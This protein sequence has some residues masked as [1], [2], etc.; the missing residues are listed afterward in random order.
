MLSFFPSFS[1]HDVLCDPTDLIWRKGTKFE[2]MTGRTA[3]IDV[4]L[5]EVFV[6]F[7]SCKANARTSV[8][9]I[10]SFSSLS[11]IDRCE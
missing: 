3:L 9:S 6:I 5:A 11:L 8:H 2:A 4:L 1:L 10:I 7:L